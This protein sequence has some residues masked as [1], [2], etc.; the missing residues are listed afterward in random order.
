MM[1]IKRMQNIVRAVSPLKAITLIT[2][3]LISGIGIQTLAANAGSSSGGDPPQPPSDSTASSGAAGSRY[4]NYWIPLVFTEAP[5]GPTIITFTSVSPVQII[6]HFDSL[7]MNGSISLPEFGYFALSTEYEPYLANGTWFETTG[8]V[9]VTVMSYN[10]VLENETNDYSWSY[11]V[12]PTNMWDQKYVVNYDDTL[13]AIMPGYDGISATVFSP[14][15]ANGQRSSNDIDLNYIGNVTLLRA[16]AGTVVYSES[17]IWL[18]QF[19]GNPETGTFAMAGIPSILWD[20]QYLISDDVTPGE[21]PNET[22]SFDFIPPQAGTLTMLSDDSYNELEFD[23]NQT[24]SVPLD[25]QEFECRRRAFGV[26]E[27]SNEFPG[28]LRFMFIDQQERL[29]VSTIPLIGRDKLSFAEIYFTLPLL[30]GREMSAGA[31]EDETAISM[32][33]VDKDGNPMLTTPELYSAGQFVSIPD[34]YALA[35][36]NKS[37]LAYEAASQYYNDSTL[38][39]IAQILFPQNMVSQ[40][41]TDEAIYPS[42]YR[43]PN[44][45]IHEVR[46]DPYPLTKV[47]NAIM[48]VEII[49]NGTQITGPFSVQI[50]VNGVEKYRERRDNGLRPDEIYEISVQEFQWFSRDVLTYSINVDI[51]NDIIELSEDDNTIQG[52]EEVVF[53]PRLRLLVYAFITALVVRVIFFVGKK[54]QR[55]RFKRP[56]SVDYKIE[57]DFFV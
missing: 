14:P 37:I 53:N 18:V 15:T 20:N 47:Q 21:P 43:M 9:Q 48:E 19:N 26:N 24:V 54:Y 46:F 27:D 30:P 2:L 49:N 36:A 25:S 1:S 12:L 52:S 44:L 50:N 16:D 32:Y 39:S 5:Y 11:A 51:D 22:S 56:V 34:F 31:I 33:T 4:F 38:A 42:W 10:G 35:I 45:A 17:A 41:P 40:Y 57:G 29:H 23:A 7:T 3:L 55:F 6:P 8:P 13:L 28:V